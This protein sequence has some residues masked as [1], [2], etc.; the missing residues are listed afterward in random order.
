MENVTIRGACVVSAGVRADGDVYIHS[1]KFTN[2][3]CSGIEIDGSGLILSPGLVDLQ[4]NGF[5]GKEFIGCDEAIGLAQEMLPERG[6]T[7]FLPTIISQPIDKYR[8]STLK[9][10]IDRAKKRK[11]A[12]VI[13]WHLEGPFLHP[14]HCGVHQ[15]TT[16]LDSL[17]EPF[18]KA[19]L[20]TGAVSLMTLAPEL[21]VAGRILEILKEYKIAAAVGHSQ[22]KTQ[23]LLKAREKGARFVTHLFNA[24]LPFH[25]RVPGI[26]GS[27]LGSRILGYTLVCDLCHVHSEAVQMAWRCHPDGLALISD[28][29]ILTGSEEKEGFFSGTKVHVS[30]EKVVTMPGGTLAG[31]LF[32]LDEL[33]RRFMKVTG[34]PLEEAIRYVTEVPA[35]YIG[36]DHAKGKIAPDYDAD[37][38]FWEGREGLPEVVATLAKGEICYATPAFWQRV[39]HE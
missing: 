39:R 32:G 17:D 18:W 20:S 13:G 3:R 28:G 22:A 9:S 27:V 6:V 14:L 2:Q 21:E 33:L 16:L 12:E 26:V 36:L 1:Q 38:V 8:P 30:G 31:C 34:C 23:D 37:C 7:A 24:M 11:G 15:P 5:G 10:S 4:I 29:A 35:R 25:H 19:V